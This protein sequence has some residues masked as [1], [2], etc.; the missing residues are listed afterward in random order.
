MNMFEN[1]I[2]DSSIIQDTLQFEVQLFLDLHLYFQRFTIDLEEAQNMH[3]L[4][5]AKKQ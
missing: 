2:K 4:L 5:P 1:K 3:Y